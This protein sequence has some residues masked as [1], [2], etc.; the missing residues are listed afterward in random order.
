MSDSE[1]RI[2][3]CSKCGVEFTCK[4]QGGCWCNN[5]QLTT[6]QLQEL[7]VN[8]ENCLCEECIKLIALTN[9]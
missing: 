9:K 6:E 4:P 7:R 1:D 8:Y 2:K 3:N 5:Y